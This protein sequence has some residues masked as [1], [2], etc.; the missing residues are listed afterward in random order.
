[1][2]QRDSILNLPGVT[3]KKVSGYNPLILDVHYRRQARC[4]HCDGKKSKYTRMVQ[5]ETIGH[6]PMVLRFEA[7]KF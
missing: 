5:H 2:P 4:V 1:M 7:Y 6:S 3:I